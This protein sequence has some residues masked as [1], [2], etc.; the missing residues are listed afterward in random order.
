MRE[1]CL[2]VSLYQGG[3]DSDALS[4]FSMTRGALTATRGDLFYVTNTK[5]SVYWKRLR[6][7]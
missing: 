1:R 7:R 2:C 4:T 6:F 3:M 5:A